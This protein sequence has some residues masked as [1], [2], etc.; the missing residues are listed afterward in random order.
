MSGWL[1]LLV[2]TSCG[3]I[4]CPK[5]VITVNCL[6]QPGTSKAELL[7]IDKNEI[8]KQFQLFGGCP[9]YCLSIDDH[10]ILNAEKD[11]DK[12]ISEIKGFQQLK[13]FFT[14]RFNVKSTVHCILHYTLDDIAFFLQNLK[15]HLHQ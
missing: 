5:S 10:F 9:R 12:I 15:K 4:P 11:I 6:C 3:W 14:C 1:H 13:E 7:S 8:I 2:P